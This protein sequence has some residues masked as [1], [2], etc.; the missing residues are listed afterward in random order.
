MS[1]KWKKFL[2]IDT[3][4]IGY[5]NSMEYC[6]IFRDLSRERIHHFML[7][8]AIIASVVMLLNLIF[9]KAM[10][11]NKYGHYNTVKDNLSDETDNLMLEDH[12]SSINR[13]F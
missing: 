3:G 10:Y 5:Q 2:S 7:L 9:F 1:G 12:S 13:D 6:P 4:A 11:F 8:T